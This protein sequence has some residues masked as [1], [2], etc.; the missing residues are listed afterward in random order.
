MNIFTYSLCI[1]F[2]F[3]L[4]HHSTLLFPY[5]EA[6][7]L[8]CPPK[9]N[10]MLSCSFCFTFWATLAI[11]ILTEVSIPVYYLLAAPVINLFLNSIYINL[12][13]ENNS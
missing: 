5:N 11:L 2:L 3:Y 12:N 4:Q 8:S 1:Y 9:L 10:Y 7:K 6:F 13:S